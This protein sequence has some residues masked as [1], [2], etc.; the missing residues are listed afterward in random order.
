MPSKIGFNLS[1]PYKEV[2]FVERSDRSEEIGDGWCW[3]VLLG[4]GWV[5]GDIQRL[6]TMRRP[7]VCSKGV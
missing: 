6:K 1:M 4:R 3:A 5:C 2:S 7:W